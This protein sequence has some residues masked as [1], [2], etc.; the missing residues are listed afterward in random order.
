M[1]ELK[2]KETD[3][4]VVAFLERIADEARRQDCTALI[5]LMRRVTGAEP[6][7]WGATI[8]GFGSYHYRYQSGREGDWFLTGF[9][10]RKN[11]LTLYLM[12][13]FEPFPELLARLG[14]ARTGKSCLYVKRLT[15]LDPA[16]LEELIR[17]SVAHT[18]ALYPER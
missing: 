6:R 11:D 10:P 1:A 16:V 12:A 5:P 14:R 7:M 15:D 3:A 13:G 9:S 8:V 2:T 4:S 17:A 18:R